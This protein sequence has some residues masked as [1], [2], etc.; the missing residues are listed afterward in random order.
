MKS[1]RI[2]G[3]LLVVDPCPYTALGVP[4]VLQKVG[5]GLEVGPPVSS[6]SRLAESVSGS[7]VV[8]LVDLPAVA[9]AGGFNEFEELLQLRASAPSLRVI[10]FTTYIHPVLVR[11]AMAEGLHGYVK[12]S[13]SPSNLARAI[14]L[15]ASGGVV[16]PH[17]QGL[18]RVDGI[19]LHD[20]D[21]ELLKLISRGAN[22]CDIAHSLSV[23]ASTLK[24]R[25]QR[26][27]LQ[28]GVKSKV[29]AAVWASRSMV[30]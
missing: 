5:L 2:E 15:V 30:V 22:N 4:R 26:L 14:E 19:A 11:R 24:R 23:S 6:I 20:E 9:Q 12:K 10:I 8:A 28:I 21:V 1:S 27:L 13:D 16:F 25:T 17:V 7:L 29:E 3:T 18:K